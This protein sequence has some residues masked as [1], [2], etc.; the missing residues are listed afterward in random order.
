MPHERASELLYDTAS[1]LRLLD[2]ELGELTPRRPAASPD[3][4]SA[5]PDESATTPAPT[6]APIARAASAVQALLTD[7]RSNRAEHDNA[8]FGHERAQIT[9]VD[10][11]KRLETIARLLDAHVGPASGSRA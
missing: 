7:I 9:L 6:G 11:E 10:V 5:Q 8:K 1:T 3:A 2:A 4:P